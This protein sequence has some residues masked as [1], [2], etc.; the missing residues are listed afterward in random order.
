[1]SETNVAISKL[2]L[3]E[4]SWEKLKGFKPNTPEYRAL[5][6]EIAALSM[7]YQRLVESVKNQA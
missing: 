3:I 5:I 2:R 7:E 1:M 6:N 4:E